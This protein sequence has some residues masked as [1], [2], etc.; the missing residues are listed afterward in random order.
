MSVT[1]NTAPARR[2]G[3]RTHFLYIAVIVAVLLGI[4]V[5][6]IWPEAAKRSRRWAPASST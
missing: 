1:D 3:G 5:G 2:S 6:F 4:A